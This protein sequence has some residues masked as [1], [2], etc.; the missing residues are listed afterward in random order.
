MKS[1]T[2]FGSASRSR[3]DFKVAIHIKTLNSRFL[4]IK[5]LIPSFY[6][7][8]EADFKKAILQ[9]CTRGYVTVFIERSPKT[10]PSNISL[11]WDKLQALKWKKLYQNL[12]TNLKVK[13]NLDAS[14]LAALEGVVQPLKLSLSLSLNEKNLIKSAF[15]EALEHC[16]RERAREGKALKKD[17]INQIQQLNIHLNNLKH[18]N[19]LQ[20]E[21]ML[22]RKKSKAANN[23]KIERAKFDFNEEIVRLKEHIS[24]FKKILGT[25]VSAAKKLDFY[26]QELLREFNTIGSK[27]SLSA[28]TLE[29]V[30]GKFVVEKIKEL[31]Q[32]LE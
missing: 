18:L 2:G 15:K 3:R 29:V 7:S 6:I 17:I 10:P 14:H 12:S 16:V 25:K 26:T 9:K 13:N 21:K 28:S 22:S 1:M 24:H 32:N 27:V 11:K 8:L 31:V 19:Y 4:D 23:E 20:K 5:F 30:E